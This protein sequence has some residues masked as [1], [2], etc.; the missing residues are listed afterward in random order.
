M[1]DA[2]QIRADHEKAMRSAPDEYSPEIVLTLL[3]AYEKLLAAV[4]PSPDTKFAYIGE[5]KQVVT[6]TDQEGDESHAAITIEWTTQK[7]F[8]ALIRK[9]AG[10]E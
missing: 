8:M 4:T 1:I 5:I 10:L 9:Q 6:F 7:E 2:A 3:D